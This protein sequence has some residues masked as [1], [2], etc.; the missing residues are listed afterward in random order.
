MERAVREVVASGAFALLS[1]T[2]LWPP[3]TVY[4]TAIAAVV[5][6][7]VTL[8]VVLLVAVGFGVGFGRL[9]RVRARRFLVGGVAA[10]VVGMVAIEVVS[11][12]TS[13]VHLVWY[14]AVLA[15]LVGGTVLG[16]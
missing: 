8:G 15:C 11:S 10:Y 6:K 1:G 12:P 3:G 9:T 13:P 4:W 16:R 7:S 2:V 5:G 14:A